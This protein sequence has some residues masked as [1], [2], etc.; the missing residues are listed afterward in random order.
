MPYLHVLNFSGETKQKKTDFFL[1]EWFF[2]FKILNRHTEYDK[3]WYPSM[4][5]VFHALFNPPI[6]WNFSVVP[7]FW[8]NIYCFS[9]QTRHFVFYSFLSCCN[10]RCSHKLFQRNWPSTPFQIKCIWLSMTGYTRHF[11]CRYSIF[12]HFG[13]CFRYGILSLFSTLIF[14][15]SGFW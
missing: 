8:P 14:I 10:G 7:A 2:C 15:F 9:I 12:H 6:W 11:G 4:H 5:S 1:W 3:K 13:S